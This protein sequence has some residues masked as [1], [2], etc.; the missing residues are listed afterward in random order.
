MK[1]KIDLRRYTILL[2]K[3]IVLIVEQQLA[4]SLTEKQTA[5]FS[6]AKFQKQNVKYKLYYIENSK[7]ISVDLDEVLTVS[8]FI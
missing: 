2:S 7:T 1:E 3:K 4:L 6:S 8:H 5:I